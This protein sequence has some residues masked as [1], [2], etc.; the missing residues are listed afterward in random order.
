MIRTHPNLKLWRIFKLMTILKPCCYFITAGQLLNQAFIQSAAFIR[1]YSCYKSGTSQSGDITVGRT[2]VR[3]HHNCFRLNVACIVTQNITDGVQEGTFPIT[4]VT[5]TKKHA[6]LLCATSQTIT[7]CLLY[8][9]N[10]FLVMV[11]NL[12]Q[13]HTPLWTIHLI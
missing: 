8:V 5:Y 9:A 6:L 11:K 4:T 13:K 7:N 2:V 1:F 3:L 12:L 10:H